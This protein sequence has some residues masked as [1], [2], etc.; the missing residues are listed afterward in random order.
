MP[1]PSTTSSHFSP[2]LSLIG[3]NFPV[4]LFRLKIWQCSNRTLP[5]LPLQKYSMV[6]LGFSMKH[7]G[8]SIGHHRFSM[9]HHG[10]D[11]VHHG[12]PWGFHRAPWYFHGSPWDVDGTGQHG[13][14]I[15]MLYP[16]CPMSMQIHTC[17]LQR[18]TYSFNI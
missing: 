8:L 10:C 4:T 3:T 17:L 7:Q 14:S 5:P 12:T 11:P 16:C 1:G 18:C 9:A 2:V 15:A 13:L 6:S